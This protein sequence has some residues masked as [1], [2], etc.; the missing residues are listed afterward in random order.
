MSNA[1]ST[2]S[3]DVYISTAP[4]L[5]AVLLEE[6]KYKWPLHFP[7]VPPFQLLKLERGGIEVSGDAQ[8]LLNCNQLL[9]TATRILVRF[10]KFRCRDFPK[11]FKKAQKIPWNN[12]V[13]TQLVHWKIS[14]HQSRLF[15]SR[16][17]EKT[18][19]DA[20]CKYRKANPA[21]KKI[22]EQ[23]AGRECSVYLRIL[24]DE[25]TFS[26]DSSGNRLHQRAYRQSSH[27]APIRENIAAALYFY[28]SDYKPIN[29]QNLID[30][31]CG[32]GTF[33]FEA[34]SFEA[35]SLWREFEFDKLPLFNAFQMTSFISE[36]SL[37]QCY[38]F[39]ISE[40]TIAEA[41]QTN[42]NFFEQK[43]RF[44]VGDLFSSSGR[45]NSSEENIIICNPPYGKRLE[46]V[47][48]KKA[49]MA[50]QK[51]FMPLKIGFIIPYPW[52]KAKQDIPNSLTVDKFL[53]FEN[54]GIESTFVVLK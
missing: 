32:S 10:E 7:Q 53:E 42:S 40:K 47:D 52:A 25:L 36:S 11:L 26:L 9:K 27:H 41:E 3:I 1:I 50:I 20:L 48:F 6:L 2:E 19:N 31:M 13:G 5:E 15:D 34:A 23:G 37:I 17:L 8:A 30:P 22:Q 33:L 14:A 24:E 51:K 38:G 44:Q 18:L 35:P 39:D 46:K 21:A 49:L 43:I 54:G 45:I 12:I 16:R 29:K 4:G 28:L